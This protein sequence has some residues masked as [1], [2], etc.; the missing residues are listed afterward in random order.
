MKK[1]K[2]NP[3]FNMKDLSQYSDEELLN[4]YK[5]SSEEKLLNI[6]C[7]DICRKYDKTYVH[8]SAIK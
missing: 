5:Q 1:N 6:L 4:L 3:F 2:F 8:W 7:K